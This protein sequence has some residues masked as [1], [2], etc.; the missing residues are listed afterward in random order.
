VVD[1]ALF[2]PS[3][4]GGG[5]ERVM[6]ILANTLVEK[7]YSVDL[8][9]VKA[10]GSFLKDLSKNVRVVNLNSSRT[11]FSIMPLVNYLKKEKPKLMMSAMHYVN[12]I[13]LIAK[14]ISRSNF[15][16]IISE[17]STLSFSLAGSSFTNL[18][19]KKLM[20]QMYP[21]ADEIIAVSQG[22]ADDLIEVLELKN[23]VVH[24]IHNPVVTK[25]LLLKKE[26]PLDHPWIK[27]NKPFILGVGRLTKAK[28]FDLLI[29][30]FAK[31]EKEISAHL[32]ILG[33]GELELELKELI[34]N[35][36][37]QDKIHMFGFVDN[38]YSWM[39]KAELFILSSSWEGFGNVLVEA[40]ACGTPVISTNCPSGPAEILEDGKLGILIPVDDIDKMAN[41]IKNVLTYSDKGNII[42]FY[43]YTPE[44]IVAQYLKVFTSGIKKI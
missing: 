23:K 19:L 2:I 26:E 16:L 8:V 42:S 41:A 36:G 25:E 13:L 4:N 32:V 28:N 15:K 14:K 29:K 35:L 7:G 43:K 20:R 37:L 38:P 39:K 34:Y 3:L 21:N 40:M 10:K 1:V 33:T 22:V 11:L 18:V 24:V 27:N 5:A 12:I 6:L 31:V 44:F 17:H 9:L 30:S